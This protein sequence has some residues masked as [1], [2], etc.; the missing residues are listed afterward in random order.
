MYPELSSW[1]YVARHGIGS[2]Y[3]YDFMYDFMYDYVYDIV[4]DLLSMKISKVLKN[5]MKCVSI[6]VDELSDRTRNCAT[7]YMGV[8][9]HLLWV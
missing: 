5:S 9:G 7:S 8:D 4:S 2:V 3:T 6:Y 1:F